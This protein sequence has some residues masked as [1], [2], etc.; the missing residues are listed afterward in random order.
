MVV[1]SLPGVPTIPEYGSSH[2]RTLFVG[3]YPPRECGIAT[4]VEDVRGAYDLLTGMRS[5]VIA[6][7]DPGGRYAYPECVV[8]VI[9]RD[10]AGS[11]RDAA[12]IVND[13]AVDVV[14][15]QHEYGLF[16]GERGSH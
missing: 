12:G 2:P 1:R 16:G 13:S 4:F 3:S 6:I 8:G 7:N 11:Y 10:D 14:N 9:D 15:I 5:D